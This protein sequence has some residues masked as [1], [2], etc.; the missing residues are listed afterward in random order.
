MA[1]AYV[2]SSKSGQKTSSPFTWSHAVAD[3]TN[4]ILVV[5]IIIINNAFPPSQPTVS[6]VTYNGVSMTRARY[7]QQ[8]SAF[9]KY[10]SSIWLLHA[11]AIGTNT[12]S[13][14]ASNLSYAEGFAADYTGA[15]QSS[16]ADA[17]A[18]ANGNGSGSKTASVTTIADNCWCV[19][20]VISSTS[21][22]T[23]SHTKRQENSSSGIMG[24]LEDS[25]AAKT[26]AGA[27][28]IG[29]NFAFSSDYAISACSFAP[30]A[31]AGPVIP[32]FMNQYRQRRR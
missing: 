29:S 1:I 26:P 15:Q 16:T 22:G 12:V 25:N 9:A 10:E 23:P 20:T 5:G 11:P 21:I 3:G 2:A 32:V 31:V 13:V 14:T 19:G 6:A 8:S 17:S 4:R 27:V 18:G 7:D 28:A 24:M 30:A